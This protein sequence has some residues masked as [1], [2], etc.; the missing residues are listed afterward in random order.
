VRVCRYS[1]EIW[2]VY[3]TLWL[4]FV[5]YPLWR[6]DALAGSPADAMAHLFIGAPSWP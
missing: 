3:K 1:L 2:V 6:V 5:A 4:I